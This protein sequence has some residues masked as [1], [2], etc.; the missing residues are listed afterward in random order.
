MSNLLLYVVTVLIWGS[1]WLAIEFQ[2]GTVAPEV[3]V[4]YRYLL[5][6]LLLF[7]WCFARGKSLAFDLKSHKR[8][9]LLGLFLFCLNYITAYY[10]QLYITSALN[11]IC[12]SCIVWMNI[13]NVRIF[14]GTKS[15]PKVVLGA[16]LGILGIV[17]LFWP[18]IGSL[19]L[20]D[21]TMLGAAISLSGAL[22]ASFGNMVSQNAQSL[23][24]PVVQSNAWGMFYGGLI[25]GIF[26]VVRG[27]PFTFDTSPEYVFS[28]LYLAVF[29]SIIAFGSYLTLLGRVGAHRAG[30]AVVMF[31]VVAIV[32]SILF[33][34]L[35]IDRFMI[36]GIGL[37]LIGNAAILGATPKKVTRIESVQTATTR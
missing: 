36:V 11:A 22:F 14:F 34:G 27:Q 29:G 5:A 8:F 20:N 19:S 26:A 23:S 4:S 24:L 17:I 18:Q 21:K 3:S 37:V 33:E 7:L 35:Q 15:E 6:A 31:P 25:T 2:L 1:T 13:I 9:F 12:F 30:Y 16:V 32:L 10:A 28:L